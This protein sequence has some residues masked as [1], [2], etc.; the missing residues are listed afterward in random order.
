MQELAAGPPSRAAQDARSALPRPWLGVSSGRRTENYTETGSA[1]G[2]DGLVWGPHTPQRQGRS[3]HRAACGSSFLCGFCSLTRWVSF[4]PRQRPGCDF[5]SAAAG[6]MGRACL[7]EPRCPCCGME[8]AASAVGAHR[9]LQCPALPSAPATHP[10]SPP[11]HRSSWSLRPHDVSRS[12][13]PSGPTLPQV[14]LAFGCFLIFLAFPS[15][16]VCDRRGRGEAPSVFII[17][18]WQ[19]HIR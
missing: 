17:L 19:I 1:P 12:R 18:L 6:G 14:L 3:L 5:S 2:E 13:S 9:S 16:A 7:R 15:H 11:H 10:S 4:S 8:G